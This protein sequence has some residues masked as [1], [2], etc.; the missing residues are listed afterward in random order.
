M[1]FKKPLMQNSTASQKTAI[2]VGLQS[3]LQKESKSYAQA[4]ADDADDAVLEEAREAASICVFTCLWGHRN[5][6][7]LGLDSHYRPRQRWRRQLSV[8]CHQSVAGA[9]FLNHHKHC[10]VQAKV[11]FGANLRWFN[12]A[13]AEDDQSTEVHALSQPE[14]ETAM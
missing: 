9:L 5:A 13:G 3:I 8:R 12:P 7:T 4:I 10:L 1:P 14:R 2:A 6:D 11:K